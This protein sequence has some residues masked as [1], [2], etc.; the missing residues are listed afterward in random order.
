MCS[1]HAPVSCPHA[2]TCR[3]EA[4]QEE[5]WRRSVEALREHLSP[6]I[7]DKYGALLS[8]SPAE[9]TPVITEATEASGDDDVEVKGQPVVVEES[10]KTVCVLL[11]PYYLCQPAR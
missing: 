6:E 11:I 2:L 5:L 8:P 3:N 4:Y 1:D 7:L 10:G 9:N